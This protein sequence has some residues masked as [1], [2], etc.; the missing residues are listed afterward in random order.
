[1]G[2]WAYR[3]M[4]V[5]DAQSAGKNLAWAAGPRNLQEKAMALKVRKKGEVF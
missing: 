3:R 2:V 1:M 5:F 4:G